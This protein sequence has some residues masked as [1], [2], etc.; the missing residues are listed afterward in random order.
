MVILLENILFAAF[1]SFPARFVLRKDRENTIRCNNLLPYI[2]YSTN[3]SMTN[4]SA[5]EEST[6]EL[7]FLTYIDLALAAH[8]KLEER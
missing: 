1:A 3:V 2:L 5:P 8:G 6:E 4:S 7:L